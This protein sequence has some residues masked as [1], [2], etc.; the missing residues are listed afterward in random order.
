RDFCYP[1]SRRLHA[2]ANQDLYRRDH[3][4]VSPEAQ[5]SYGTHVQEDDRVLREGPVRRC[6]TRRGPAA[7][8]PS[9]YIS[10]EPAPSSRLILTPEKSAGALSILPALCYTG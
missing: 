1:R 3:R 9:L 7:P 10:R 4:Q 5:T 2:A 6:G 8:A